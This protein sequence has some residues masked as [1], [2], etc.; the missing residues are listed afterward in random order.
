MTN[1]KILI[2]VPENTNWNRD[3]TIAIVL[4][5]DGKQVADYDLVTGIT[6]ENI[7][8]NLF[9]TIDEECVPKG[10]MIFRAVW[11]EFRDQMPAIIGSK[12]ETII[13]ESEKIKDVRV[14]KRPWDYKNSG[15]NFVSFKERSDRI[16]ICRSC[17]LFNHDT[18]ICEINGL[19]MIYETKNA[20]GFCPEGL[21]GIAENANPNYTPQP[22]GQDKFEEELEKYLEGLQ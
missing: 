22:S 7:N 1:K 15:I 11:A 12:E 8:G 17:P 16:S 3:E 6:I 14:S 5:D 2:D 4:N 18:G 10:K 19:D 20:N 13:I 9:M 21:W